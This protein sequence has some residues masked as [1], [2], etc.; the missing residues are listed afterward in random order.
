MNDASVAPATR[1]VAPARTMGAQPWR[2]TLAEADL[3]NICGTTGRA[4]VPGGLSVCGPSLG[5]LRAAPAQRLQTQGSEAAMVLQGGATWHRATRVHRHA[6]EGATP[7]TSRLLRQDVVDPDNARALARLQPV[8]RELPVFSFRSH[9]PFNN[10]W[11]A[12]LWGIAMPFAVAQPASE[13]Q[14]NVL[15]VR[16]LP[17]YCQVV[18]NPQLRGVP[19]YA[20]IAGC[21][22]RFNHFCPALVALLRAEQA[23]SPKTTRKYYLQNAQD[24]LRYTRTHWAPTCQG[25][26]QVRLAEMRARMLATM[27]K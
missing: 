4:G 7:R 20:G 15:E 14:P 25:E 3:P 18:F 27:L 26:S 8:R 13:W 22:E 5:R 11:A 12:A 21:G 16:Q 19:G 9:R 2:Y 23:T 6:A 10:R 24:H 17:P 1:S